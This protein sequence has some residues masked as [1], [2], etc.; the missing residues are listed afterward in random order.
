M[1]EQARIEMRD[2][3]EGDESEIATAVQAKRHRTAAK[4]SWEFSWPSFVVSLQKYFIFFFDS[5]F[6]Q[7]ELEIFCNKS[8]GI[9]RMF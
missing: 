2:R 3:N 4:D 1:L 7:H 6:V 5:E 9:K 8:P